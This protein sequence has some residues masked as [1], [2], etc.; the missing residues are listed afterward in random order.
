MRVPLKTSPEVFRKGFE[1][2]HIMKNNEIEESRR[3][4]PY[5]EPPQ[6]RQELKTTTYEYQMPFN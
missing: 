1:T 4:E 6:A 3:V 5:P 2:V